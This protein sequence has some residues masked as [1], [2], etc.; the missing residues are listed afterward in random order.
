MFWRRKNIADNE[1]YR[2]IAS[3]EEARK[4]WS[5]IQAWRICDEDSFE[6]QI[7]KLLAE[8]RYSYLL[9]QA[10]Q[11]EYVNR[12]YFEFQELS[13]KR[14]LETQTLYSQQ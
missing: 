2:L 12:W 14:K 10:R 7:P 4:K 1:Q 8:I 9:R 5:E 11:R 3:I 6:A 13:H